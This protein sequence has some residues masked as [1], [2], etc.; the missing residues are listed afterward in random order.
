[1]TGYSLY[2]VDLTEG[3][4]GNEGA[5][6]MFYFSCKLNG[7]PGAGGHMAIRHSKSN[8]HVG[9]EWPGLPWHSG[10]DVDWTVRFAGLVK[11]SVRWEKRNRGHPLAATGP[12]HRPIPQ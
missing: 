7:E 6:D 3:R 10:L 4:E 2:R 1:M 8:L 9:E 12:E 5:E 11:A